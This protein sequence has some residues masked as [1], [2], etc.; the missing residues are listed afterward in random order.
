MDESAS[1]IATN[2]ESDLRYHEVKSGETLYGIGE[3]YGVSV[4][5][6]QRLNELGKKE[7]IYPAQT[8]IVGLEGR[9]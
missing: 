8:L 5:Q 1:I 3:R 4:D 7:T 9:R 6:L 2:E